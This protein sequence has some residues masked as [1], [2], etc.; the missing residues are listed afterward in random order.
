MSRSFV[1]S[2]FRATHNS[3]SGEAR[4]SLRAQLDGGVRQVELDIVDSAYRRH[5]YRVGHGVAGRETSN[6]DGNPDDDALGSWLKTIEAWCSE[7]PRHVPITIYL[8]P[9]RDLTDPDSFADGNL[10]ALNALIADIFGERLYRADVLGGDCWPLLNDLAGRVICV[11]SGNVETRRGYLG[12]G[13]R[14]PSVGLDDAGTVVEVHVSGLGDLWYWSGRRAGDHVV[15]LR[16]GRIGPG[17]SPAVSVRDGTAVLVYGDGDALWVR[18][19]QVDRETLEVDWQT[20]PRRG[21]PT[22]ADWP[23]P[24]VRRLDRDRVRVTYESSA[25]RL[26][27][28]GIVDVEGVTWDSVTPASAAASDA[29]WSA[30]HARSEAGSVCV[31]SVPHPRGDGSELLRYA[32]EALDD[33]P[34]AYEQMLFVE[35]KWEPEDGDADVADGRRFVATAARAGAKGQ[36]RAWREDG[37][38]V[39][40]WGFGEEMCAM[41]VPPNFPAT[42]YPGAD[43]YR[44][45]CDRHGAV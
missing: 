12:D 6:G 32:T 7:H 27:R 5:G 15:W 37:K 34:I 21:A 24:V 10:A 14:E 8:D 33:A 23:S 41:S 3:F 13:G 19:G 22:A 26:A 43:W 31:L 42:D 4:G 36:T 30:K 28:E 40:L 9:K 17:R 29:G 38:V 20:R 35:G 16:H 2:V 1:D 44:N 25:G 45:F 39:R 11:L 18:L